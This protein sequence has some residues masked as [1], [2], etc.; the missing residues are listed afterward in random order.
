MIL[1]LAWLL[2]LLLS[3]DQSIYRF[4][5]LEAVLLRKLWKRLVIK[6]AVDQLDPCEVRGNMRSTKSGIEDGEAS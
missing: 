4:I 5:K 3:I 1:H 6:P 2:L